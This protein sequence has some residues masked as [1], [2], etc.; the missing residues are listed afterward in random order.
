MSD[1][2]KGA[3]YG[4]AADRTQNPHTHG[5]ICRVACGQQRT[6]RPLLGHW[7]ADRGT[8][9]NTRLGQG[10][11]RAASPGAIS[12]TCARFTENTRNSQFCSHW[13]QKS[14]GLQRP[15]IC[16]LP[17]GTCCQARRKFGNGCRDGRRMRRLIESDD[18]ATIVL[19]ADISK[20]A[21]L[22]GY[23][24]THRIGEGLKV[25]ME[26]YVQHLTQ[27]SKA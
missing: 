11:C 13:L 22:L 3:G 18:K 20:A 24:P 21:K 10:R 16:R 9:G 15:H 7:Q 27:Q 23:Q 26:W 2:M 14:P 17:T 25:A 4:N 8:S 5:A 12:G 19:L 1:V 6:D